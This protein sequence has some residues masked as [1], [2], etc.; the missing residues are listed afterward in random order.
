MPGPPSVGA[1]GDG[2]VQPGH[3]RRLGWGKQHT[4]PTAGPDPAPGGAVLGV[5]GPG[6]MPTP[7]P[8]CLRWVL[9]SCQ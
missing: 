5:L 4:H 8:G 9:A 3:V 2:G 1:C 6:V 7:S